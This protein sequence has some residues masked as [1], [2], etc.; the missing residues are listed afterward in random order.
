MSLVEEGY[1]ATA[2][3]IYWSPHCVE[4]KGLGLAGSG[5]RLGKSGVLAVWGV[6]L[7]SY[8][9]SVIPATSDFVFMAL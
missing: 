5:H 7:S 2:V 1:N 8:G 9:N 4:D 3:L 6:S